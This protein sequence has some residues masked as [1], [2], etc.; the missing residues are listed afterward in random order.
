MP[1]VLARLKRTP[2]P[3][4]PM[5]RART[6]WRESSWFLEK[7]QEIICI[8]ESNQPNQRTD[9][10]DGQQLIRI[11]FKSEQAKFAATVDQ[12]DTQYFG[13]PRS[14]QRHRKGLVPFHAV[15]VCLLSE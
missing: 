5:N 4:Q 12:Q 15:S 6:F 2:A 3:I 8:S 7:L 10:A 14:K 11:Q 1:S 13:D 9:C